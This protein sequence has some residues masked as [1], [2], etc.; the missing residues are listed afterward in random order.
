MC[1]ARSAGTRAAHLDVRRGFS[2]LDDAS[3]AILK[4]F[5]T[6]LCQDNRQDSMRV[7]DQQVMV[8][9]LACSIDSNNDS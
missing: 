5:A 2:Q 8:Y 3:H 6:K 9:A 7:A 1:G 4:A